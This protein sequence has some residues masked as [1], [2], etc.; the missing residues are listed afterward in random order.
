MRRFEL[1][2]A[3]AALGASATAISVSRAILGDAPDFHLH[4][5]VAPSLATRPLFFVLGAFAGLS[6][7]S[8]IACSCKRWRRSTGSTAGPS[9]C[10]RR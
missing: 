2:V 10:A 4:T 7:S 3:I 9:K 5:L 6:R 1:Q 8:T